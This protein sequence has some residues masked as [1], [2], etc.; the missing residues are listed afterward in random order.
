MS[1]GGSS[2]RPAWR[3]DRQRIAGLLAAW[4][5]SGARWR[6]VA[7]LGCEVYRISGDGR[8]AGLH[9]DLA[10]RIVPLTGG[11]AAVETELRWLAV[12]AEAGMHVP[13]PVPDRRGRWFT[14]EETPGAP[15]RAVL[16]LQWLPGRI[17]EAGLREAH[18]QRLGRFIARLHACAKRPAAATLATTGRLAYVPDLAAWADGRI[19][20]A[21]R[22]PLQLRRAIASAAAR[23]HDQLSELPKSPACWGFL[24]GD[25]HLWNVLQHGNQAGAIDFSECGFGH[26]ALDAA[27]ALQY[28]KHPLPERPTPAVAYTRLRDALLEGYAQARTLP[29]GFAR[30]IDLYIAARTIA[31]IEWIF[32]DWPTLDHRPWGPAFLDKGEAMLQYDQ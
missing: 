8:E 5:L 32:E 11:P 21:H 10:L 7:H 25:L 13:R 1:A 29:A 23:L 14:L 18:L 20:I 22:M 26:H 3:I 24:H 16:M 12:L 9:R 31:T 28:L 17:L 2:N 19:A 27:A 4:G 30:Q 6:R 15:A